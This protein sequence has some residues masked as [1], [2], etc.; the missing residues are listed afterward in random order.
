MK[1]FNSH[2]NDKNESLLEQEEQRT[3][4]R[5]HISVSALDEILPQMQEDSLCFV[6]YR[7]RFKRL[8]LTFIS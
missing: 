6:D 1:H 2:I 8:A 5:S 4:S 3:L 7:V